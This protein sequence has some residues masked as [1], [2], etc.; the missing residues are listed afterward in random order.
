MFFNL[1]RATAYSKVP[2]ILPQKPLCEPSR[3]HLHGTSKCSRTNPFSSVAYQNLHGFSLFVGTHS[4]GL[5]SSTSSS[6]PS[7]FYVT[8]LMSTHTDPYSGIFVVGFI[9]VVL[10]DKPLL[11]YR[12][13]ALKS[14]YSGFLVKSSYYQPYVYSGACEYIGRHFFL[15]PVSPLTAYQQ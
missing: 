14:S 10:Y 6:L 4:Y 9:V 2:K 11:Q 5:L 7:Y 8:L 1:V 15:S 13:L 3:A 12:P